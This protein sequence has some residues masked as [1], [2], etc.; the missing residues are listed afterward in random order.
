MPFDREE[1]NLVVEEYDPAIRIIEEGDEEYLSCT[2]PASFE[3]MS[4][5]IATTDTL[6]LFL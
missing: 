1:D 5:E 4:C 3:T 6:L 2:L